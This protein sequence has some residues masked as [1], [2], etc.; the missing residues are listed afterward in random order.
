MHRKDENKEKEA[1]KGQKEKNNNLPNI[2]SV[3]KYFGQIKATIFFS[4]H[5]IAVRIVTSSQD[6]QISSF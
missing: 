2:D 3:T 6:R 4:S 1:R 5:F